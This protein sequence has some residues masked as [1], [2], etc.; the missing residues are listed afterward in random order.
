LI[1]LLAKD[2]SAHGKEWLQEWE[3]LIMLIRNGLFKTIAWIIAE[4]P[5]VNND[6]SEQRPLTVIT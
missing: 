1:V 2:I 5:L 4:K 6:V 3:H